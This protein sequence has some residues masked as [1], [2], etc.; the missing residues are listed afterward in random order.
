MPPEFKL[1]SIRLARRYLRRIMWGSLVA[2]LGFLVLAVGVKLQLF[3]AMFSTLFGAA[4]G[5]WLAT[6]VIRTSLGD[7]LKGPQ[8]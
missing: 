6:D 7:H 5:L 2:G 1:E 8:P 4:L 3:W